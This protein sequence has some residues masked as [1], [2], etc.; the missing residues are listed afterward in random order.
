MKKIAFIGV[1]GIPANFKGVGGIEIRVENLA[2]QL[3]KLGFPV[4][5]FVRNWATTPALLNYEGIKLIHLPTINTKHAD[6]G[7]HSALASIYVCFSNHNV[8]CYEAIGPAFFCFLPKLFG[9]KIITTI[10][11]LDWQR[12]KWGR[13]AKIFLKLG[14]KIA[15]KLS[16]KVV[17]VSAELQDYYEKKGYATELIPSAI[18]M[19]ERHKAQLIKNKYGFKGNDYILY[20][21]R[22]VPEK[23]IEW[24]IKAYKKLSPKY[25]LVLVGGSS[26]SQVYV[27]KLKK[28]AVRHPKIIFTG[29][30]FGQE[31]E[32]LISNCRLFVQP[33]K[34]EGSS[35]SVIEAIQYKRPILAADI[36]SNKELINDERFLFKSDSYADFYRRFTQR[37]G[38]RQLFV[39]P[40]RNLV[41]NSWHQFALKFSQIIG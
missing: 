8:I 31:K 20:L 19:G 21:G 11:C 33:S 24:L 25:K 6:A 10:H 3:V 23:R 30:L 16:S 22:F 27:E 9:K 35:I 14:E 17:V 37:L 13:M 28:L 15:L 4:S 5:V 39:K 12:D 29:Y 32:E 2:K 36:A 40:N 34:L 41:E 38:K 7:I 18:Q 1:K 26:H